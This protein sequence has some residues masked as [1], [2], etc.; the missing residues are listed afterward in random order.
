[1]NGLKSGSVHWPARAPVKQ[2]VPWRRSVRKVSARTEQPHQFQCGVDAVRHQL[3]HLVG[4]GAVVD[5]RM[6]DARVPQFSGP[7]RAPAR[8]SPPW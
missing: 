8:A 3:A 7:L 4:D 2:T 1:M 6:V 5:Q